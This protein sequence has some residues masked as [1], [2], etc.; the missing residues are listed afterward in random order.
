MLVGH[1]CTLELGSAYLIHF[2]NCEGQARCEVVSVLI[3]Y[4]RSN[5]GSDHK[6]RSGTTS[7]LLSPV[8]H[9]VYTPTNHTYTP[10]THTYTPSTHTYT[11]PSSSTSNC[12]ASLT[13]LPVSPS[14]NTLPRPP[15]F[16]LTLP[17]PLTR[18]ATSASLTR[19]FPSPAL[20]LP[21]SSGGASTLTTASGG[22]SR[23]STLN[24]QE[25]LVDPCLA[26][27]QENFKHL[28][29]FNTFLSPLNLATCILNYLLQT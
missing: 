1:W 13:Q 22:G 7:S 15:P 11:L 27:L 16:T 3:S 12:Y 20:R 28:Q 21:A 18:P 2:L 6:S 9:N 17:R 8:S 4:F 29:V 24:R 19:D 5:C 10:S 26:L 23:D 25:L 14:H